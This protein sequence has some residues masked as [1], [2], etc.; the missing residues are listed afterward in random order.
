MK[1]APAR[2][3]Q[4]ATMMK[5]LLVCTNSLMIAPDKTIQLATDQAGQLTAGGTGAVD[6][7][8]DKMM[9]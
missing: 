9:P 4:E 7:A 1:R 6:E 5:R 2:S 3:Q 8:V